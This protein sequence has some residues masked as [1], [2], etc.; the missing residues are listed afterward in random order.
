MSDRYILANLGYD[1]RAFNNI[2]TYKGLK[3]LIKQYQD[4]HGKFD[5]VPLKLQFLQSL[6]IAPHF[7]ISKIRKLRNNLEHEYSLPTFDEVK[8]AIEVADLF[9]NAT[10]NKVFNK[11]ASLFHFGT[12]VNKHFFKKFVSVKFDHLT[13]FKVS[14]KDKVDAFK[15]LRGNCL[16][17]FHTAII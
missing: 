12:K 8:E 2:N 6:N 15:T 9:I 13:G 14:V 5:G 1:F 3:G 7:I 10:E 17:Q 11:S 16:Y 4:Q